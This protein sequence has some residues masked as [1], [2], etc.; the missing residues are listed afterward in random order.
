MTTLTIPR[1]HNG[2]PQSGNGGWS[3]GAL[4]ALL[5]DEDT[6]SPVRVRLLAPPPLDTPLDVTREDDQLVADSVM[7]AELV[8]DAQ[9]TPVAPV[10][11]AEAQAASERFHGHTEHP[12][13]TCFVCGTD[14]APGD[15][16]R[17]FAGPI[18]AGRVAA[19][20]TPT[21]TG[22]ADIWAALDCPGAWA[23]DFGDRLLVLGTITARVDRTPVSGEPHVV[24]A[25]AR[26]EDGRKAFAA[27]SIYAPDGAL[28]ATAE[29]IWIR[30]DPDFLAGA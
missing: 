25:E 6:S 17:L 21:E 29:Q 16:L 30:V 10:T 23:A 8:P 26:G 1:R 18:E 14:R 2:P 19:P 22:V 20:W 5:L 15:G 28:I 9:L 3:A 24:V 7:R 27:T 12:F 4:A 13:P 11:L